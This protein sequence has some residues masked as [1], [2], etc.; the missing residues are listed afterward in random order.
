LSSNLSSPPPP[1]PHNLS[2]YLALYNSM[3]QEYEKKNRALFTFRE[4]Y[5]ETG[6]P[7][8]LPA[9]FSGRNRDKWMEIVY[10]DEKF[11]WYWA[12]LSSQGRTIIPC[13]CATS[14]MNQP[15]TPYS[16]VLF[17]S[18]FTSVS[19]V[20]RG[21]TRSSLPVHP[22]LPASYNQ[23]LHLHQEKND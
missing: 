4:T 16:F 15:R 13:T 18:P 10:G 19:I 5:Q 11:F 6:D 8:R 21:Q 2:F 1:P 23:S 12:D 7:A 14:Q 22:Y 9:H 20:S 3:E 17:E